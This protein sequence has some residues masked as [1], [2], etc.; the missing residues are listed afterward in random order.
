VVK[1]IEEYLSTQFDER[2]KLPSNAE[3]LPMRTSYRPGL[4]ISPELGQ[5]E[6]AYNMSLIGILQ[7]IVELGQVDVCLKCSMIMSS[8][9]ALPRGGHYLYQLLQTF[10]YLKKYHNTGMVFDPSD[11]VIDE[12]SSELKDW[13][14]S[15][16]GHLQGK[17][18]IPTN[19]PGP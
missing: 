17:E 6:A 16:F 3:T 18:E 14:S 1:N 4:D 19:I 9:T 2:W 8:H 5:T 15:D 7:W 10:G 12:S 11:P 13:T